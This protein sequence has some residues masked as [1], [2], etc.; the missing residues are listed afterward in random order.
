M[1]ARCLSFFAG[2]LLAVC[3]AAPMAAI[4]TGTTSP[5]GFLVSVSQDLPA[6]STYTAASES[7]RPPGP[8]QKV[9]NGVEQPLLRSVTLSGSEVVFDPEDDTLALNRFHDRP[10]IAEM[11][12]LAD[13]VVIRAPLRLPGTRLLIRARELAFEDTGSEPAAIITTP[14]PFTL[15]RS[16]V[17]KDGTAGQAGGD[18][19]LEIE[20]LQTTGKMPRLVLNGG[21]GQDPGPGRN[22]T[23]GSYP[24]RPFSYS[25]QHDL[26]YREHYTYVVVTKKDTWGDLRKKPTNGSNATPGGQPGNGGAAG[27][28]ISSVAAAVDLVAQEGGAAGAPSPAYRG[29]RGKPW[30]AIKTESWP[31]ATAF[32]PKITVLDRGA[33]ANGRDAPARTGVP[34]AKGEF[35]AIPLPRDGWDTPAAEAAE[36]ARARD[37]HLGGYLEQANAMAVTHLNRLARILEREPQRAEEFAAVQ[38]GWLLLGHALVNGLD[39]FGN[40]PGWTPMLSLEANY[41]TYK[42]ESR[43]ALRSLALA[44]WLTQHW[45]NQDAREQALKDS[46]QLLALDRE[47]AQRRFDNGRRLLPVLATEKANLQA[48]MDSL[49]TALAE[50][51][52]HVTEK[53]REDKERERVQKAAISGAATVLSTLAFVGVTAASGGTLSPVA[54]GLLVGGAG[55]AAGAQD[56]LYNQPAAVSERRV[57]GYFDRLEQD[58]RIIE[59]QK[60]LAALD[61]GL[62]NRPQAFTAALDQ[63][64]DAYSE[65]TRRDVEDEVQ[66]H[67]SA[68]IAEAELDQA[69]RDNPEFS[70]L[71]DR[72]IKVVTRRQLYVQKLAEAAQTLEQAVGEVA[73]LQHTTDRVQRALDSNVVDHRL[74]MDVYAMAQA[75]RDRLLRYQYYLIKAYEYRML[76]PGPAHY[77]SNKLYDKL[78]ANFGLDAAADKT[79]TELPPYD[80]E[81]PLFKEL[82][83]AYTE[84]LREIAA[85]TLRGLNEERPAP[86][87]VTKLLTLAPLELDSLNREGAV[88]IDL[89]RRVLVGSDVNARL[90]SVDVDSGLSGFDLRNPS[91]SLPVNAEISVEP[92]NQ[93]ELRWNGGR[94][95]FQFGTGAAANA[96]RWGFTWE[97]L[98]GQF[99]PYGDSREKDDLL[100]V[101]LDDGD[102]KGKTRVEFLPGARTQLII[103]QET[104]PEEAATLNKLALRVTLQ[105]NKAF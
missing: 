75:A 24:L 62:A 52:R 32:K 9:F 14:S 89:A 46:L 102:S 27:K 38:H 72:L 94:Y 69:R 82:E 100:K 33:S 71:L 45:N 43:Q 10:D 40:P 99:V 36:L 3:G 34:G 49:Q 16:K 6:A 35:I 23:N 87:R 2:A 95:L 101:L 20:T 91:D 61:P 96:V 90:V 4:Q 12:L 97:S 30:R 105:K 58:E 65:V 64:A 77:F 66:R 104:S 13:R 11:T 68:S 44:H 56:Y 74:R 85:R 60:Q 84:V 67:M 92:G 98:T 86:T 81:S 47:A 76:E 37:L 51:E 88:S 18:I 17:G 42:A 59:A 103:R 26:I 70:A 79:T 78:A 28:L 7:R 48:D 93:A 22:G 8:E 31:D 57:S 55:V 53:F 80:V 15:A 5:A 39:F 50:A 83:L 54:A 29:G 73:D 41:R 19:R 1:V 21:K 63:A 25:N